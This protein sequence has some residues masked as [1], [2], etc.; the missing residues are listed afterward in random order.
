MPP[1]IKGAAVPTRPSAD[2]AAASWRG[3]PDHRALSPFMY[4]TGTLPSSPAAAPA[5]VVLALRA[6]PRGWISRS[7]ARG[8][9]SHDYDARLQLRDVKE[10]I[11]TELASVHFTPNREEMLERL[12][13]RIRRWD[14]HPGDPPLGR[15]AP[16]PTRSPA[17]AAERVLRHLESGC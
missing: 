7:T 15:F 2:A 5:S 17:E 11:G 6:T 10:W 3:R 1:G 12:S 4:A 16:D 8:R 9:L 13:S 14:E